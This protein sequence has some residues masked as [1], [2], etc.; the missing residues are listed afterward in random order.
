MFDLSQHDLMSV[1]VDSSAKTPEE[2]QNLLYSTEDQKKWIGSWIHG[3]DCRAKILK[4]E[5][6]VFETHRSTGAG[7]EYQPGGSRHGETHY[8]GPCTLT[9]VWSYKGTR[10]PITIEVTTNYGKF[11]WDPRSN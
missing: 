11:M 7:A 8:T 4:C 3:D 9:F 2:L 10:P 1:T 6:Q 5:S